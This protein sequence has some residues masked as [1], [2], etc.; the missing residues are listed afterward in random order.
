MANVTIKDLSVVMEVKN[1]GV[2]FEIHDTSGK[3]LGDLVVT[4]GG[5]VWCKGK[6]KP[7]NGEK[8]SWEAFIRWM[9]E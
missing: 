8:V 7:A 1:R 2:E 9:Q 4:K 3:H 5:L 6:T